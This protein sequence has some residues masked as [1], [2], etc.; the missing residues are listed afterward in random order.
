[1]RM[2][3]R[4]LCFISFAAMP[5]FALACSMVPGYKVPTN[6]ELAAA[7]DTIVVARLT[8]EKAGP[9]FWEGS[10][11]A[12]PEVLLKGGNLPTIVEIVGARFSNGGRNPTRSNPR[13]LREANPDALMGGCVRYIFA[14]DMKLVL[15]LKRNDY[16]EMVPY[17]SSF[18]RDSE[19]VPDENALWV[20]AVREY[21]NISTFPKK[22]WKTRL[23]SRIAELRSNKDDLDSMAIAKDMEIEIKG[24]RL[25]PYD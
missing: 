20:K 7:A 19:D 11:F 12:T 23:L 18:S 17:R 5:T 9:N 6:L 25:L 24:K 3:F 2:S 13:E 22:E 10:V 4:A 8:S 1:M 15:F 16:G 21:A 14:K